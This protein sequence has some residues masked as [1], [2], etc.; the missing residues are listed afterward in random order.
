MYG[1]RPDI[2]GSPEKA[3][4]LTTKTT[5]R[6][7]HLT[8]FFRC[9]GFAKGFTRRGMLAAEIDSHIMKI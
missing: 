3:G 4:H 8:D 5:R 9:P 6:A 2:N 7:G 1:K